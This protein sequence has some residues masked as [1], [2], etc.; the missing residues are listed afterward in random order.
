MSMTPNGAITKRPTPTT[1]N[2]VG[3]PV[4]L[5][6]ARSLDLGPSFL[7]AWILQFKTEVGESF[8]G[9]GNLTSQI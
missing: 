9:N 5:V 6:V 8:C 1:P 4:S 3:H 7:Y 2:A